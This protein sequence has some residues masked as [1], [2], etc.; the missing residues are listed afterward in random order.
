MDDAFEAFA[1]PIRR[2]L[3]CLLHEHD[4]TTSDIDQLSRALAASAE[5]ATAHDVRIHLH[6][7]HL[8]KL[9]AAEFI[10]FDPRSGDI[11]YQPHTFVDRI[12]RSQAL[13]CG[14]REAPQDL[15]IDS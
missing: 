9:Q 1:H 5:D 8:P 13:E 12:I 11:R 15:S 7:V 3:L 4:S 14:D 2:E 6:H 10:E